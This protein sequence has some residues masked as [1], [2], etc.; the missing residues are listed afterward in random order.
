MSEL[1]EVSRA[2]A[3]LE[4]NTSAHHHRSHNA[5]LLLSVI[6]P[7]YNEEAALEILCREIMAAL[8]QQREDFEIIF[9]ND[10][11]TDRS[12]SILESLANT[13]APRIRVITGSGRLGQTAAL[14]RGL[15]SAQGDTLITLDADLQNDPADIPLLIQKLQQG[16]DVVCGWRK[17][18]QDKPV[19]SF[20][21]K[22]ANRLQRMLTGLPVHDI[23]CTLRAYRR[24]C[25]EEL[26]L[27]RPGEHRFIPL[28]LSSRGYRISEIEVHHRS[29]RYGQS[30]YNHKRAFKVIADFVRI[31]FVLRV[32][33]KRK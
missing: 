23:S 9:V 3:A 10:G 4:G 33:K 24:K 21:S 31:L 30:K 2:Q 32:L 26:S 13:Y 20:L 7:V 12:L 5:G 28:I 18:R 19:K 29:R 6:V 22:L 17:A 14:K 1:N 25:L 16:Y 8:A 15:D 11:S 27:S